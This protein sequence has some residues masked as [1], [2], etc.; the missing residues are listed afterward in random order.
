[1]TM[2]ED[3]M[4]NRS[5]EI[6]SDPFLLSSL[7]V[8]QLEGI[9]RQAEELVHRDGLSEK[10]KKHLDK[11]IRKISSIVQHARKVDGYY[12]EILDS[13]FYFSFVSIDEGSDEV[14]Y[15]VLDGERTE[16]VL[17]FNDPCDVYEFDRDPLNFC[18]NSSNEEFGLLIPIVADRPYLAPSWYAK[19]KLGYKDAFEVKLSMDVEC[20]ADASIPQ[21]NPLKAKT[22]I[23][24]IDKVTNTITKLPINTPD[25]LQIGIGD[26]NSKLVVLANISYCCAPVNGNVSGPVLTP[27]DMCVY[28]AI[29]SLYEAGNRF[30]TLHSINN[31]FHG[32]GLSR[33]GTSIRMT[34]KQKK[35]YEEAVEKLRHSF[36]K[37]DLSN[38]YQKHNLPY[39][40]FIIDDALVSARKATVKV[41]GRI[42][43]CYEIKESPFLL[44]IARSKGQ[45]I[46]MPAEIQELKMIGC[47]GLNVT[48]ENIVLMQHLIR[49]VFSNFTNPKMLIDTIIREVVGDSYSQLSSSVQ[50]NKRS[51]IVKKIIS[52]LS[53]WKDGGYIDDYKVEKVGK[54]I[55]AVEVFRNGKKPLRKCKKPN[56]LK[57]KIKHS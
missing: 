30:I 31:F 39:E 40:S 10:E 24:S 8:D 3:K 53:Y 2:E 18:A 12:R 37:V 13:G 41:N 14:V 56:L 7:S 6:K 32:P 19:N 52:I 5:R 45:V 38:D 47:K 33:E 25:M 17:R 28:C 4:L 29:C 11:S 34:E 1:M 50:R 48:T 9:L 44:E 36:L 51:D 35:E 20:S 23:A 15:L 22:I 27:F 55:R 16:H 49:G 54:T 57:T 43:E 46:S 21:I 42:C 26:N